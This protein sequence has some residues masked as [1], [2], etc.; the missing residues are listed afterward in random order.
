MSE[1]DQG[2]SVNH[3]VSFAAGIVLCRWLAENTS[4]DLALLGLPATVVLV[5]YYSYKAYVFIRVK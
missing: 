3:M 5:A 2:Q 1:S 4:I